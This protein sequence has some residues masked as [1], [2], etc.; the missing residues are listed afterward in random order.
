ML[1]DV[2][3]R[4]ARAS[5]FPVLC[6]F[7]ISGCGVLGVCSNSCPKDYVHMGPDC[8]CTGPWKDSNPT[9]TTAHEANDHYIVRRFFCKDVSD[10]SD[11]GFCDVTRSAASCQ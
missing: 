11:R 1:K 10:N 8:G 4:L 2:L 9:P 5:V 6:S 7:M 3:V